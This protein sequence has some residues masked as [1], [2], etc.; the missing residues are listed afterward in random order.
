MPDL[1]LVDC[2]GDELRLLDGGYIATYCGADG[3]YSLRGPKFLV[4]PA[5]AEEIIE[6]LAEEFPTVTLSERVRTRLAAAGRNLAQAWE[7]VRVAAL[8]L[9]KGLEND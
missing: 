5:Q 8:V 4:E 3:S 9:A 1:T 2:V 6:W 7:H